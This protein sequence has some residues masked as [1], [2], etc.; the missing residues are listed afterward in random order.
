M[1]HLACLEGN[2][3]A[4]I[5]TLAILPGNALDAPKI[6]IANGIQPKLFFQILCLLSSICVSLREI[7]LII[8]LV[9]TC[10][11]NR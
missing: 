7:G 1:I 11:G 4:A 8:T 10:S 3:A 2:G 9:L 6:V 5:Q